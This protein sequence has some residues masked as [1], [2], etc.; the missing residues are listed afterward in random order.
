[1]TD[2]ETRL[3]ALAA[4]AFPPTPD[5]AGAWGEGSGRATAVRPRARRR[6]ALV[7]ALAALLVPAGALP[8]P[9]VREWLGISEHVRVHRV[10]HLPPPGR[11]PGGVRVDVF[12][13][14]Y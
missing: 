13:G 1:M 12:R 10:P 8:V 6:R 3:R 9:R 4:D 2:L 7:L 5:L 11:L 14:G